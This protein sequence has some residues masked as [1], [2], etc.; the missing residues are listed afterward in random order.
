MM[1][2]R[3]SKTAL[4]TTLMLLGPTPGLAQPADAWFVGGIAGSSALSANGRH[5]L[6]MSDI[7]VSQYK[8]ETG[9]AGNLFVGKHLNDWVTVQANY[10]WNANDLTL[11]SAQTGS[12]ISTY[13]EQP[14]DSAQ[15]AVVGDLLVYF[16]ARDSGLRPYLS[17][18]GGMLRLASHPNGSV[19]AVGAI[20]PNSE[21]TEH[22]PVLR[23]A[24]GMDVVAGPKWRVRYS[25]S[26]SLSR[27]SISQQLTPPAL[28]RLANFQNLVG[29]VRTF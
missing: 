2:T 24:V 4:A 27:N 25:F 6:T 29:L 1:F 14:R 15:H 3:L 28:R 11:V 10:I 21:L 20:P 16:R 12:G 22:R 18:G 23:V 8:P 9:L 26:E 19:V 17:V 5:V 13:Y 7:A